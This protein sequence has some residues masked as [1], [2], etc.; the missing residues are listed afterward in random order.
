[1]RRN[2]TDETVAK[3]VSGANATVDELC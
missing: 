1:M 2:I 3:L